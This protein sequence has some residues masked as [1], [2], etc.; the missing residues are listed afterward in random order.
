MSTITKSNSSRAVARRNQVAMAMFNTV[1]AIARRHFREDLLSFDDLVQEGV[2]E[3]LVAIGDHDPRRHKTTLVQYARS[4]AWNAMRK[5]CRDARR[6]LPALREADLATG[7]DDR[8]SYDRAARD[9]SPAARVDD[10]DELASLVGAHCSPRES[11]ALSAL[12]GITGRDPETLTGVGRSIGIGRDRVRQV[13][14]RAIENLR[15][16]VNG[17]WP[18]VYERAHQRL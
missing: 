8:T 15:S 2:A 4:R 3:I 17:E 9:E 5:L 6:G 10:R 1:R 18:S 7:D 16:A 14:D 12:Y 11:L 13:K